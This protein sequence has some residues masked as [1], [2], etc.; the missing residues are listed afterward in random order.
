M[1]PHGRVSVDIWKV[2]CADECVYDVV[3]AWGGVWGVRACLLPVMWGC[4][5]GIETRELTGE[6]A[7]V[8]SF[9]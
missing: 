9:G 2:L 1:T 7:G 4:F 8:L 5:Y 6:V 3:V